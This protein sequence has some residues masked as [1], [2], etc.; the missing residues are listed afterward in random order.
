MLVLATSLLLAACG[1]GMLTPMH[2]FTTNDSFTLQRPARNFVDVVMEVG[3]AN[4]YRIS[5]IDRGNNSVV[6]TDNAPMLASAVVGRIA[7]RS[8]TVALVGSREVRLEIMMTGNMSTATQR[9]A[10]GRLAEL[11]AALSARL[12]GA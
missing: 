5:G 1:M 12:N 6:L 9:Q 3:R 8:I 10:E 11:K 2:Q 7:Q 4:G